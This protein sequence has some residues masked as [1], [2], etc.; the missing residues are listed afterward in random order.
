M[1]SGIELTA[2]ESREPR[3]TEGGRRGTS[4]AA[5]NQQTIFLVTATP[6]EIAELIARC[7]DNDEVFSSVA[8]GRAAAPGA[9]DADQQPR[10]DAPAVGQADRRATESRVNLQSLVNQLSQYA[11]QAG[12]EIHPR[13]A[14]HSRA[15]QLDLY[16]GRSNEPRDSESS[17]LT[18][19][20]CA[21]IGVRSTVG[22]SK[23]PVDG[24][25]NVRCRS[26]IGRRSS[27]Y[28]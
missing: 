2:P 24:G 23:R 15:V 12:R 5:E 3:E 16:D 14:E 25:K 7:I 21:A 11:N 27:A 1:E 22:R 17:R 13:D 18:Q 8:F 28:R 26:G 19:T 4:T 20:A 9:V 10:T 6:Q